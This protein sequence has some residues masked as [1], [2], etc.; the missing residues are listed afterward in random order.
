MHRHIIYG[1]CPYGYTAQV[2]QDGEIVDEYTAGNSPFDSQGYINPDSPGAV[3]LRT[4]QVYARRTA[5]DLAEEWGVSPSS[6]SEDE[7][8]VSH[9]SEMFG[10]EV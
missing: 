9:L 3:S 10:V 2:V 4:L 1:A 7:D 5:Q 6:V 8:I